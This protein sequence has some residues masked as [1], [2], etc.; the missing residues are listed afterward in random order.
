MSRLRSVSHW[1][2]GTEHEWCYF[3]VFSSLYHSNWTFTK[4][5]LWRIFLFFLFFFLDSHFHWLLM[6]S[7]SKFLQTDMCFFLWHLLFVPV[8]L[9]KFKCF[10]FVPYCTLAE[11]DR[12]D[13]LTVPASWEGVWGCRTTFVHPVSADS[14]ARLF[15]PT[16]CITI[17][18]HSVQFIYVYD[19]IIITHWPYTRQKKKKNCVYSTS[20]LY[21]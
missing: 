5:M 13:R 4:D 17:I 8:D 1:E 11:Y 16:T 15:A 2:T 20:P 18:V 7:S 10:L 21:Q 6:C 9:G 3:L 14:H 19:I 12:L